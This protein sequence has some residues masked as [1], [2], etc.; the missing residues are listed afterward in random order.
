MTLE[1]FDRLVTEMINDRGQME[2][3]TELGR[4]Q[5]KDANLDHWSLGQQ[6]NLMAYYDEITGIELQAL[7]IYNKLPGRLW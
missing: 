3:L 4:N 6:F 5:M 2:A 7:R 1:E